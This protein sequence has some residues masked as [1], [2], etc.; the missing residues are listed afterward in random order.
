MSKYVISVLLQENLVAAS[1]SDHMT[2]CERVV[3]M[4]YLMDEESLCLALS[5]GNILMF[6]IATSELENVGGV[7]EM[8][9]VCM[10]W[11]PEQDLV[12]VVTGGDKLILM[13]KDFDLLTETGLHQE[14]FGVGKYGWGGG[15]G[16]L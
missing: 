15:W 2:S 14:E 10:G 8:G 12:V 16:T 7:E 5:G 11:S 1:L 13:T 9:V 3:G 4:E 6:H